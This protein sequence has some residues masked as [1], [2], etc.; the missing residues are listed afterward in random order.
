MA[1]RKTKLHCIYK[2]DTRRR[3]S[4]ASNGRENRNNKQ[5]KAMCAISSDRRAALNEHIPSVNPSKLEI[6]IG[7]L[8]ASTGIFTLG[9]LYG[10]AS[11][12]A[13]VSRPPFETPFHLFGAHSQQ[14]NICAWRRVDH[15]VLSQMKMNQNSLFIVENYF[16]AFLSFSFFSKATWPNFTLIPIFG[17]KFRNR[18]KSHKTSVCLTTTSKICYAFRLAFRRSFEL[19]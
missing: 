2:C 4:D 12:F 7:A 17:R 14:R 15:T 18:F 16:N 9:G 13:L 10:S 11:R 5:S 6:S 3:T 19:K 8:T 1:I